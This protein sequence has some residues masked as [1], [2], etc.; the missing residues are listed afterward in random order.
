MFG[1]FPKNN[2]ESESHALF[3]QQTEQA[4]QAEGKSAYF[5]LHRSRFAAI[6]AALKGTPPGTKVLEIGVTP[7]QC[8]RLLVKAGYQV[9]G[10]DL[11]PASRQELWTQLGIDVR[12]ANLERESLPFPSATFEWVIFSEVLEHL[13]FSPLPVLREFQRVLRPGGKI[14][15]TTPNELY[16]K[17]R[18]QALGRLLCWQSLL[19][20]AEFQ[21]QM[22]LEGE[23]RYTTHSRLYTL[24]ELCWTIEQAGFKIQQKE[25][26]AAWER[27]GLGEKGRWKS[28]PLRVLAKSLLATLTKML[29]QTRSMLLV[30]GEKIS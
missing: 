26:V 14:L 27:V 1:L 8:T 13:V 18:L 2:H 12:Q 30:V 22:R 20:A 23:A 6:L 15:L 29:P 9:S 5:R 10:L 4:A 7:G 28:Q 17:S 3:F 21:H 25:Y 19:S 24:A 11:N 16:F